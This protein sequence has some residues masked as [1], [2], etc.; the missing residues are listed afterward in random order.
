MMCKNNDYFV[1]FDKKRGFICKT[2]VKNKLLKALMTVFSYFCAIKF[3][4]MH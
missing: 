4:K 2:N 3:D 1:R